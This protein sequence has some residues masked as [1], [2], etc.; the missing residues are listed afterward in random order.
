LFQKSF[1]V[2]SG[3]GRGSYDVTGQVQQLVAESGVSVGL[4]NLFVHHT[5]ASLMLCENADP[6]VRRDLEMFLAR[7]VADGDP[8]YEHNYEGPDDMAA[9]IRTVLTQSSITVPVTSGRA[10]L[11]TWQGV[12][13][14]EHRTHPHQRHITVTV[15]GA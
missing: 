3:R 5:S 4:C 6:S 9:H 10:A 8:R 15:Q 13:L 7:L 14:L 2:G 11:G 1:V 12:Y